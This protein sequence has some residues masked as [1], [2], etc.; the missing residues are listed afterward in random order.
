LKKLL[1]K[2]NSTGFEQVIINGT[3]QE[4]N[5]LLL[6]GTPQELNGVLLKGTP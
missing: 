5:G 6:N 1:F 3:P 4:L 2:R